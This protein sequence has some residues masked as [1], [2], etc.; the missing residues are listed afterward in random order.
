VEQV[1]LNLIHNAIKFTSPGG[2]IHVSA[3][4]EESFL[5]VSIADTGVGISPSELPRVFERFY[6]SDKAR[7]SD[8]TG[9]GLAIAKHIVLAHA[10][11]IRVESEQGKG[12]TFTFTLPLA[13]APA[14]VGNS[15]TGLSAA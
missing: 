7:R 10:G 14:P 13:E 3:K 11:T 9:L 1:L 15:E 2:H 5:A 8:G 12:S 6:K 4:L